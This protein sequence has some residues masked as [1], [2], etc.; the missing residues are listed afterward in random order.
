MITTDAPIPAF[1]VPVPIPI[2]GICGLTNTQYPLIQMQKLKTDCEFFFPNF[3]TQKYILSSMGISASLV[4]TPNMTFYIYFVYL[5]E[6][7]ELSRIF[8]FTLLPSERLIKIT[9]VP[10]LVNAKCHRRY[11]IRWRSWRRERRCCVRF[12]TPMKLCVSSRAMSWLTGVW[13]TACIHIS[14]WSSDREHMGCHTKT[15]AGG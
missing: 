14:T 1:S 7:P 13:C 2:F 12:E 3:E 8:W 4:I 15:G 6:H 11:L 5:V 9:L 10:L